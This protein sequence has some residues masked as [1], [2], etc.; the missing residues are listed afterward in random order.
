[1]T[2]ARGWWR[3]WRWPV[4]LAAATGFLVWN[5][6]FDLWLGQ[7]ERQYLWE[8]ARHALGEGRA[9]S[10]RGS[11]AA[12]I[13]G[14]LLVASA[15]AAVVVAAILGAAWLGYRSGIRRSSQP[16]ASIDT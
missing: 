10:L 14:G 5:L 11:V 8:N 12:S 2:G 7:G 1:M 9:V 4:V 13:E 3:T 6:V 16:R 15:W